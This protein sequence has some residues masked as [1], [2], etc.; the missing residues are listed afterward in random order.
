MG[1]G[2]VVNGL[3]DLSNQI[4]W[5]KNELAELKDENALLRAHIAKLEAE[6]ADWPEEEQ[7][8]T[9]VGARDS[10]ASEVLLSSSCQS[11]ER[12]VK[13]YVATMVIGELVAFEGQPPSG[14]LPCDGREVSRDE[15]PE[16]FAVICGAYGTVSEKVTAFKLPDF[17]SG[18]ASELE[19]A[20]YAIKV[21]EA[22]P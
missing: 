16:L 15:Y 4:R 8:E 6:K 2:A 11:A 17:R 13:D 12:R 18:L 5:L 1:G 19:A 22:Q 7:K 10:E 3:I 14:C 9:S 21:K 20:T